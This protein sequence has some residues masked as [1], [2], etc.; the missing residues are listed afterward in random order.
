MTVHAGDLK[1][2]FPGRKLYV[3]VVSGNTTYHEPDLKSD[4]PTR[5]SHR[6]NVNF[7]IC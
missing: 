3:N 6:K 7:L 2:L 5:V 4:V 1:H